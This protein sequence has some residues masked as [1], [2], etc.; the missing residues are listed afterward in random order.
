M[1]RVLPRTGWKVAATQSLPTMTPRL[2]VL[3]EIRC[4]RSS[5]CFLRKGGH[6]RHS[7]HILKI[8]YKSSFQ[9]TGKA[10]TFI[11]KI[12]VPHI[13]LHNIRVSSAGSPA[14]PN[15]SSPGRKGKLPC[16]DGNEVF[17]T[18]CHQLP[19][20]GMS[21]SH[22]SPQMALINDSLHP[23]APYMASW[24]LPA[25]PGRWGTMGRL[26]AG[27]FP[28]PG[29]FGPYQPKTPRFDCPK[30]DEEGKYEHGG[31]RKWNDGIMVWSSG[32]RAAAGSLT[33]QNR[34][35]FPAALPHHL[36]WRFRNT[37]I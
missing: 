32:E 11:R 21:L 23:R 26:R 19:N 2:K 5:Q 6:E 1:L 8:S 35:C 9:Y 17:Q 28:S 22:M 13:Y 30:S 15:H 20:S 37:R 34:L 7:K 18:H 29:Y 10:R 14:L 16:W 4:W 27:H 24:A 25:L 36:F 12:L 33:Q 31:T 3:L